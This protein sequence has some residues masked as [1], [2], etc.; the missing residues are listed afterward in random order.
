MDLMER[1]PGQ[2]QPW[3]S[4]SD[5]EDIHESRGTADA[6]GVQQLDHSLTAGYLLAGSS[7]SPPAAAGF[8]LPISSATKQASNRRLTREEREA[9]EREE[10]SLLRDNGII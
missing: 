10:I 6:P 8:M 3:G 9:A 2:V 7:L 4:G 5:P 1:M